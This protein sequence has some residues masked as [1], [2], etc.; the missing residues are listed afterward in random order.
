M[1]SSKLLTIGLLLGV[2]YVIVI[3]LFTKQFFNG[4]QLPVKGLG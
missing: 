1:D 4:S 3:A 2:F